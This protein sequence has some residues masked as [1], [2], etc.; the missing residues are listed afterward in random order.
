MADMRAKNRQLVEQ[1][2]T[3]V[4]ATALPGEGLRRPQG[5]DTTAPTGTALP[6]GRVAAGRPGAETLTPGEELGRS[7]RAV[8]DVARSVASGAT[9][10]FADEIAAA[11]N[12]AFG[13]DTFAENL[14]A[15][16]ARDLEIDPR[17]K[18]AGEVAGTVATAVATGGA[19]PAFGLTAAPRTIAGFA[20]RGALEG[21]VFG[22]IS[23]FGR[24]E[25]LENR[26]FNAVHGG[27][28]GA[29]TGG[30]LGGLV[31][32]LV[33]GSAR[34]TVQ[35]VSDEAQ[36]AYQAAENAGVIIKRQGVAR[37]VDKMSK[38]LADEGFDQTLHPRAFA[39]FRR[40]AAGA[41]E[42]QTLKGMEVL[43][44]IVRNAGTTNDPSE[45]RLV[46]LMIGQIDEFVEGLG[47]R[48]L[49]SAAGRAGAD[50]TARQATRQA[51]SELKNARKL[52][53]ISRKA[54]LVNGLVNRAGVRAGQFSGS[55]YENALRTEFRALAQ[56]AKRL[57][58]FTKTEQAFI[59][60]VASGTKIR[61]ALRTLGKAA[62]TGIVSTALG[63]QLGASAAGFPG[64]AATLGGGAAGRA[65][66]TAGTRG[67][68]DDVL[69]EILRPVTPG[70]TAA[71]AAEANALRAATQGVVAAER[72]TGILPVGPSAR[73][74][75]R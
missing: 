68:V 52:W 55:G 29:G 49:L 74:R 6:G 45:G 40:L 61:N 32:G 37:M 25:G 35:A 17:I 58:T 69:T 18:V 66:A 20:G 19:A 72:N 9:L 30:A 62:P 73:R 75:V 31:R 65:A 71:T 70:P 38:M 7:F 63:A 60:K 33:G 34:P 1:L 41:D 27:L 12:S 11:A 59:K 56:N 64:A 54:E 39:A 46:G 14:E 44:R 48:D 50:K 36:A 67:A 42:N 22:G 51:V 10:G 53:Q 26:V 4:E 2:L 28:V 13:P 21:G 43:R 57:R 8:D 15:E 3:P 23:G 16:R 24:G 47:R 5:P